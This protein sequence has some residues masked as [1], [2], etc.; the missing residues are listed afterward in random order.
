[1]HSFGTRYAEGDDSVKRGIV[2]FARTKL[3]GSS[4]HPD[5]WEESMIIGGFT[6]QF[7]K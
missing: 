2:E 7:D 4:V 3:L 5:Q 6:R 1:M